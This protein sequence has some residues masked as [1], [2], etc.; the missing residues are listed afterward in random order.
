[1]TRGRWLEVRLSPADGLIPGWIWAACM[2][3]I[4]LIL[5]GY[6]ET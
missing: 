4:G 1:M 5:L 6:R 3:A 2:T